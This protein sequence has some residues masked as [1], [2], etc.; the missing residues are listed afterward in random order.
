[1]TNPRPKI[2]LDST[3]GSNLLAQISGDPGLPQPK[4]TVS[5]WQVPSHPAVGSAQSKVLPRTT[6]FLIIGSG[7]T[8]LGVAKTLLED[9]TS[10]SKTVT[11]LDARGLCSGATGRNG[12]QLVKPYA[13]RFAQLADDFGLETATKIARL[14]LYTLEE[15][16]RL[17]DSYD[18]NLRREAVARR[19]T[20]RIVY[21]DKAS[22]GRV[23]AAVDL[24]E[25]HLPE[26][27]GS[28][29]RVPKEEVE[30]GWNV[31][32]GY[33]GYK[34]PAGVCWPYRLVT[35]VFKRLQDK[36]GGSGRLNIETHTP[37]TAILYD[38]DTDPAHPYMV[39][40]PRGIIR[41]A[42][43]V[44]CNNGHASHLLPHLRGK[45]WP[46]RGTMSSQEPGHKFPDLSS[47]M[48]WTFLRDMHYDKPSGTLELGWW[49]A[50]QNAPAGDVWI[51]GDHKRVEEIFTADDSQVGE[52][53]VETVSNIL[54]RVFT[55]KWMPQKP[56]VQ[57]IW[58]GVMSRTGD[59]LPFVGWLC[60]TA[61]GRPGKGE[62]IAAGWNSYGMTNGL[63]SG[64]AVALM[65][66][67]KDPPD[68]FPSAYLPTE[69]RLNKP[70]FTA[71]A[72]TLR[73]LDES[74]IGA[75]LQPSLE[76]R[77]KL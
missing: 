5:S 48:S 56:K 61:T 25:T 22:W 28:F 8:G 68:W 38:A 51:G 75:T 10:G 63:T 59:T 15:M 19:V 45:I 64:R 12:G 77:P 52:E 7:I 16:H 27:K 39:V 44:H 14:A 37:A 11:V 29:Q 6:D 72:A 49:Y 76:G 31:K 4:P 57:R 73:F 54:P 66:L 34:F 65:M 71:E 17:A 62:W 70:A 74:G 2:W 26:E 40:T 36:Y 55:E 3:I 13:L 24:Y 43:L 33:G 46:L 69:E 35:G 60:S 9:P 18:D 1:M 53:S 67:G 41:T 23:Q 21:M 32:G 58:T 30:S 42:A 50:L 47:K 20:K